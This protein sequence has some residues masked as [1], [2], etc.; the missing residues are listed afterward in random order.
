MHWDSNYSGVLLYRETVDVSGAVGRLTI[1]HDE[2]Y[3]RAVY[4]AG[5]EEQL[6]AHLTRWYSGCRLQDYA[7]PALRKERSARI[8]IVD[9]SALVNSALAKLSSGDMGSESIWSRKI[10]AY[11]VALRQMNLDRCA[12]DKPSPKKSRLED[13]SQ[14]WQEL[15]E[16][17]IDPRGTDHQRRVWAGLSQ[18]ELG[19]TTSYKGLADAIDNPRA[20]RAVGTANGANPISIVVPCHRVIA[21]NGGLGGYGGGLVRKSWL[22]SAECMQHLLMDYSKPKGSD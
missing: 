4:F 11:L 9:Q 3:L 1:I 20:C 5:R 6:N 22:L 13:V 12:V 17:P 14:A 16:L 2:R 8:Q 19:K 21:A 15:G 7:E 10:K 18:I